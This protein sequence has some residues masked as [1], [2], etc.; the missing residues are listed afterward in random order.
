MFFMPKKIIIS[1]IAIATLL[2]T[3]ICMI[4]ITF[5]DR[6]G[7]E[8][9]F[10][11]KGENGSWLSITDDLYPFESYRLLWS[12]RYPSLKHAKHSAGACAADDKP[13]F[14]Y[15][16]N[17]KAGR[18]FIKNSYPNGEKFII[19]LGRFVSS[20]GRQVSGLFVGGGLPVTD[21]D[22]KEGNN[23]EL[24]MNYY[25]GSRFFHI[26]CNVNEGIQDASGNSQIPSTWEFVGSKVLEASERDLTILS[27]HRIMVN[28]VPVEVERTMFYEVGKKY[29]TFNTT[30][31]NPTTA[32][33]TLSYI[34]GDEPWLGN[35]YTFSKG[36]IGWDQAGL[37]QTETLVDAKK[38]SYIGL[39]DYGNPLIGESHNFTNKANFIE[40]DPLMPPDVAYVAN[41]F[42]KVAPPEKKVPLSSYNNRVVSLQ[43]GPYILDPKS[44]LSFTIKV[45]MADN[46]PKTGMPVKPDTRSSIK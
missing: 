40:W 23:N 21:P 6:L 18:G 19:N 9:L 15:E 7:N 3:V 1:S 12:I 46:D 43:W 28:N 38:T 42:G 27:K 13:C 45:G 14:Y 26:W 22:Y 33:T 36:N 31:K 5:I 30:I 24:G 35:Y 37:L 17:E 10:F 4:R 41:Q 29:I 34:Y 2:L 39:F 16:W 32:P 20:N 8:G 11:L 25:D 44:S